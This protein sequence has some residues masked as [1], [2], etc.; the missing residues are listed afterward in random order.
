[1]SE[2]AQYN[3]QAILGAAYFMWERQG[4]PERRAQDHWLGAIRKERSV[5][6][7][8]GNEPIEDEER[9]LAGCPDVNMPA[10]LTRDVLGG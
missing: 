1:M 8:Q 3:E 4:H 2:S 5:Q 7:G 10:L 9:I 6:P